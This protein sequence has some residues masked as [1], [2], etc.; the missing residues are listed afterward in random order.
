MRETLKL[1]DG[2]T[3]APGHADPAAVLAGQAV[4]LPHNAVDMPLTYFDEACFQKPFTYQRV[5][6]ADPAWAGRRVRLRFDG[7][8]AD[9][10]VFVNGV[11]VVAHPDGYTPFTADLTDHLGDGQAVVTV[12]LDG[13]ENPAIPPFGA[14]IDYLT[15]AGIYRDVWLEV[16]PERHLTNAR[17]LTPDA[18]SDDKTVVIR[19]EVTAPGPV[20]ARL[21][22]GD[23]EI[24]ATEGEGEL[25]L[26]GLTGLR[27]WSLDDPALY[28]VELTL[29]DTGDVTTH[30]FGFR[31]AE[32]TPEGFVLNGRP[33]K[34]RGLNRHQSWAHAGYAAGRHAQER[35]AEILKRDLGCN[36]VRTSHY[37]QSPWFIDRCDEIGLL[38]FEE[39]PGWQHIGDQAWQDASVENVRAM[40]RR[41]WNHPSIVI[42]GV[43]INESQDNH[44]FYVRT[45]AVARELDPTRA[46]GGVRFITDSEMLE[47]VYTMNDF[48]LDESELPLIQRPRTPLRAQTE[49]TGLKAPV[50]YV[51]TEYNGHMFPTKAGDPELRQMEHVIRH[52]DVLNAA[53]GDPNIAGCIGWCMFDYN[54]HKDFGAGDR[55]CHHGVMDIWREPKFAAHAYSSQKPQSEGVVM[56]PVTFWARG[57]RNIGGVLPLIVLT[58]CDEVEFECAGVTRRVGPDR[59]RFPHLPH[60]P[61]II[62]DRHIGPEELGLWGM[63]WHPGSITGLIDGKPVARRDFVAD[64]LP[65]TLQVAPDLESV[66]ADGDIDLRVM[67]RALDQAGNR[68]PFL[69]G[70]VDVTVEGPATLIGPHARP[71]QGGTTGMWL[72]LTGDAGQIRITARH[73][74]FADGVAVVTV[75]Q[76]GSI[77]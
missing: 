7:A 71:L 5:I 55:I 48:I 20:R 75:G 34:L 68:L 4:R 41:D 8:M 10:R 11:Q 32:W 51:V 16:I 14:Q 36:M 42:W 47:D 63:S 44:D 25:T 61:V 17:I 73:P 76:E 37:P 59:E 38:V 18:L 3:F 58:N 28:T 39:I 27:L 6:A 62:D 49:V 56:E 9:S 2:W 13:S 30:R 64:P 29:P 69:A 66:P 35:D 53:H 22:D 24:A 77:R 74:Q 50:P 12:H 15:Y 70:C 33:V 21:L 67:I 60:P 46:T 52:L 26:S 45:N 57:E 54:T 1:N 40:I 43:R 72:R 65:T 23:R 31:T 19:P